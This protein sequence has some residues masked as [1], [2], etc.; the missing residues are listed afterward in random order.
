[1]ILNDINMKNIVE[2]ENISLDYFYD[3]LLDGELPYRIT[4]YDKYGHFDKEFFLSEEQ[5]TDLIERLKK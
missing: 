5:G 4:L 1:M 3:R 2:T